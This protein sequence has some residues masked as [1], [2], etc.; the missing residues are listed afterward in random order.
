MVGMTVKSRISSSDWSWSPSAAAGSGGLRFQRWGG[1]LRS[2]SEGKSRRSSSAAARQPSSVSSR[3]STIA[4]SKRTQVVKLDAPMAR[5]PPSPLPL[6]LPRL[7]TIKDRLMPT[8]FFVAYRTFHLCLLHSLVDLLIN[9]YAASDVVKARPLNLLLWMH[10]K[11]S[12]V[13]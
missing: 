3:G 1:G 5:P 7:R 13:D 8:A 6:L 4:I 10:T 11:C 12:M 9:G 2:R